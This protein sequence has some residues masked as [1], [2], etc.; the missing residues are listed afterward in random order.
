MIV[1]LLSLQFGLC[2]WGIYHAVSGRHNVVEADYYTKALHWDQLL[3]MQQ[4]SNALGW[5]TELQVG[6]AE[7]T[8]GQRALIFRMSDAA[9]GIQNAHVAVT[10]F[11]HARPRELRNTTLNMIE[12]GVYAASVPLE[13]RGVWEF[14]I[15]AKRGAHTF[16]DSVQKELAP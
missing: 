9:A 6:D 4:A 16:I 13:I 8:G 10:F 12:P 7:T 11:H 2:G 5:K 14:R 3:A 15:T 1:G